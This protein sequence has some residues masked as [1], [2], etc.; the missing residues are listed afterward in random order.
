MLLGL[1]EGQTVREEGVEGREELRLEKQAVPRLHTQFRT[2][3]KLFQLDLR[4]VRNLWMALLRTTHD[5]VQTSEM[6]PWLQCR[7]GLKG[8]KKTCIIGER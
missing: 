6:T 7:E 4:P 3:Y 5:H 1:R 8:I 2:L